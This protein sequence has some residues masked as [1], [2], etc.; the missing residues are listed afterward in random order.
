[1]NTDSGLSLSD[2]DIFSAAVEI[3]AGE[4]RDAFLDRVCRGDHARRSEIERL[5]A[6]C[7][8]NSENPL[9]VVINQLALGETG[10]PESG[11]VSDPT[12]AS[13]TDPK[14]PLTVDRYKIREQIGV[15]GMGVVY[16][17][18]QTTPVRR[19]VALKVIKPGLNS[20]EVVARF[21]A[22]RQA[23]ALM[24][25]PNIAHVIDGATLE[26]G[27]PYFVMELVNG[28]PI[29]DFCDANKLPNQERLKLFLD[30]C[31]AVQH[32]HQ[33]GVI[34]RD[35][36][37]SNI[38]VTMSDDKPVPKVID[39]G[40]AKALSQPLTDHSIYTAY[41][42]M[43]GTPLYMSP[44]QAQ[45]S[46]IDVDTRS[47][48][49]SL[50]VL[51]Y[52]LLTGLTPFDKDTLKKSGLDEMRRLIREVDPPRP[53]Q[54]V[55]TL[56][57]KI[58]ST[59]SGDRGIDPR[60]LSRSLSG[61]LDW[62][63][64]K[65]LEK[66]RKRRYQSP[67][68]FAK[69]VKQF[70]AGEAVEACPPSVR[71]RLQKYVRRNRGL[72]CVAT[73]L[74]LAFG[75]SVT[76]A[77][78]AQKA[79]QAALVAKDEAEE[80]KDAA[81]AAQALGEKRLKQSRID[82]DRALT[83]L[84]TIVSEVSSAEF[85]QFP[86]VDRLR[87]EIVAK[88]LKFYEEI[89]HEHDND[90]HAREQ[91]ALA[92]N[93]I[94]RI[95]E[96]NGDHAA[97]LRQVNIAV[98]SLE[99]LVKE[100]PT[101]LRFPFSLSE[102]LFSRMHLSPR[103]DAERL[104][105]AERCLEIWNACDK[106]GH[107]IAPDGLALIHYKVAEKL[108]PSLPRARQLVQKSLEITESR[109]LAPIAPPLIWMGD[110]ASEEKDHD[111]AIAF[112]RRGIEAYETLAAHPDKRN[113]HIERWLAA[114]ATAR[115]AAVYEKS[116]RT[117]DAEDAY[118]VAVTKSEQLFRE[119][120][121]TVLI[122][123]ALIQRTV[124]LI[125]FLDRDD[126][127]D[128]ADA[129]LSQMIDRFPGLQPVYYD[130]AMTSV[131]ESQ[132]ARA[133]AAFERAIEESP[134][135]Y[136]CFLEYADFLVK[137]PILRLRDSDKAIAYSRKATELAP[138]EID[139]RYSLARKLSE[140]LGQRDEAI[141]ILDKLLQADPDHVDALRLRCEIHRAT[142]NLKLA[143]PDID[144]A[145]TIR[146][147]VPNYISRFNVHLR[148]KK[149]DAALEDLQSAEL[150]S[151]TDAYVMAGYGWYFQGQSDYPE[152]LTRW[153]RSVDIHPYNA[154]NIRNR[155]R[156][157][158]ELGNYAEALKDFNKAI[159]LLPTELTLISGISQRE[160][161]DCPSADYRDGMARIYDRA[162][163]LNH[164]SAESL[165]TRAGMF[166][167]TGQWDR[168]LADFKEI[169]SQGEAIYYDL[170]LSALLELRLDDLD[171]YRSRC[172]RLVADAASDGPAIERQFA[173]WVSALAPD[174]LKDYAP[175]IAMIRRNVN[176][177]PKS[178]A[179]LNTL[180][181]ILFRAGSIEE[182]KAVLE[183]TLKISDNAGFSRSYPHFVL[184]LAEHRLGNAEAAVASYKTALELTASEFS[185]DPPW[186]RRMTIERFDKE[187]ESAIG[188]V[189]E[190]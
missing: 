182:A 84:D 188:K 19:K 29:T 62:I 64:M 28:V 134:T 78:E 7:A 39:F 21:E 34:H 145:I 55:S 146:P 25:H 96:G 33:K 149:F 103:S 138:D 119:Y 22:E 51:L 43:V 63:V 133:S 114:E 175:A 112:Y 92:H 10:R 18:E 108:A 121:A 90:P 177:D 158:F 65:A 131:S 173:V 102:A 82:F 157:H 88:A 66:D 148:R 59:V 48:V 156:I 110:R 75:L 140:A 73:L 186:M 50:G 107:P 106:A 37:P 52:E 169:D 126:R 15:G 35:L 80:Q 2:R 123:M 4:A 180:G 147:D 164:R 44:E 178:F 45:F 105:D 1:M 143:L 118:R 176:E 89:V 8:G 128:E 95:H 72:L 93:K 125:G 141:G 170:Y 69:D 26:D 120:G 5:L 83:S 130:L 20:Q 76:Y 142:G 152:A 160:I 71:Y 167:Q 124:N 166:A 57:A 184:A 171:G 104:A 127:G 36:K 135:D 150:L 162:V 136:R 68:D 116:G 86:G 151:P 11:P 6:A 30:V 13:P 3:P 153:T 179:G 31:S 181:T 111:S 122:R 190:P 85:A 109:D 12:F 163:E 9:E 101:E 23:L 56:N 117:A 42:Q 161:S 38:M 99:R 77:N 27:R 155:G 174:A 79:S 74:L 139:A 67:R 91:H 185:G 49:Y 97:A 17:A 14:F 87:G 144:R 168:S 189:D 172:E 129:V 94:A 60:V 24:D 46:A 100:N 47:D 32:A 132:H 159:E 61:E 183:S 41:G 81:V 54:R 70:L 53:S 58:A 137:C 165:R 113:R 98:E 16:V 115:L 187:V 154:W 40:V